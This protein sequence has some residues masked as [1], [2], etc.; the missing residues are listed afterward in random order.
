MT[1]RAILKNAWFINKLLITTGSEVER[2]NFSILK[3]EST[4]SS[5]KLASPGGGIIT[6]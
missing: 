4:K 3:S 6:L 5:R 2:R 1:D